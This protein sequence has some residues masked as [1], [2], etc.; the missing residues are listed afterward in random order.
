MWNWF[1]KDQSNIM[2]RKIQP[3]PAT[4]ATIQ[5]PATPAGDYEIRT[6]VADFNGERFGVRIKDGIGYTRSK[7]ATDR[8]RQVGYTVIDRSKED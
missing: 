7:D 4:Q 6:P 2:A 8:C 1:H 5:P 3:E